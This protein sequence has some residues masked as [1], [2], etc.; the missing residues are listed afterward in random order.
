LPFRERDTTRAAKIAQ[1]LDDA[2]RMLA[3]HPID[4]RYVLT[5]LGGYRA[6]LDMNRRQ[7]TPAGG[8]A[9]TWALPVADSGLSPPLTAWRPP[10]VHGRSDCGAVCLLFSYSVNVASAVASAGDSGLYVDQD[11]P[12]FCIWNCPDHGAGSGAGSVVG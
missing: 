5:P 7:P 8:F 3:A 10:A 9:T 1:T 11:L 2:G 6:A 12:N 4:D